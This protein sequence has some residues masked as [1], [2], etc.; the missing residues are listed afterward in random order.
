M[1]TGS[2]LSNKMN[3]LWVST[4]AS[5]TVAAPVTTLATPGVMDANTQCTR[6]TRPAEMALAITTLTTGVPKSLCFMSSGCDTPV[7]MRG[8]EPARSTTDSPTRD[9]SRGAIRQ[10][11]MPAR[12]KIIPGTATPSE[13]RCAHVGTAEQ[14]V[15][16]L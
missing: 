14:H 3:A 12:I 8:A 10:K 13:K 9:L 1:S 2:L 6:R 11:E 4:T 7:T 5:P 16:E 15:D